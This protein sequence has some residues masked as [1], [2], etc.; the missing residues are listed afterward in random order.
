MAAVKVRL[1][2][3]SLLAAAVLAGCGS[4]KPTAGQVIRAAETTA[5][6][7]GYKISG[8]GLITSSRTGT[9]AMTLAGSFDRANKTGAFLTAVE[10]DG[11]RIAI[12][13]VVSEL[14]VYMSASALPGGSSITGGKS[15][16]KIDMSK[17]QSAV[18]TGSIP[19]STDPTQFVDYLRAVSSKTTQLGTASIMGVQTTHYKAT[20][21]L[22]RYPNLVA[23]ARRAAVAS[24]IKQL[25]LLL[26]SHSLPLDVWIDNHSLVRRLGLSLSECAANVHTS[27]K[28]T[29][30]LYDYGPQLQV[31]IPPAS[32]V[33]DL[34]PLLSSGLKHVKLACS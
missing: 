23:P 10:V 7:P 12:P 30:N 16:V 9:V 19:T 31:K 20:I 27:F 25:E 33:Y 11:R 14:T 13:E 8:S 34:T 24:S 29:M 18:G 22:D 26:G 5:Q 6:A 32:S 21:D 17:A 2:A 28:M 15:W 4:S 3:A 1:I